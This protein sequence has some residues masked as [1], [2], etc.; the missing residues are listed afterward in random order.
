[1]KKLLIAAL[2]LFLLGSID[3]FCQKKTEEPVEILLFISTRC[4]PC[5]RVKKE[6]LP[7][8]KEKYGERV[9]IEELNIIDD[10][11]SYAKFLALGNKYNWHPKGVPTPTLFID[12]KFLVGANDIKKYLELHIDTVL[13]AKKQVR[14]SKTKA[15]SALIVSRF[16]V[17]TPIGVICAGLIDGINPCAFTAIIFFISF[18]ALRGY[19]RRYILAIGLSFISAVFIVYV[20]LGLGLFSFLYQLKAYWAVVKILYIA[21]AMLCFVLAGLAFYDFVKFRR[22]G[23]TQRLV[24]QLP[25]GLKERIHRV[26]RLHYRKEEDGGEGKN[27][28]LRLILSAFI[29]GVFVSVFEA[30]CT[31]QVYLPTIVFVL[32]MTTFK[33]KAFFYLLLYNLMF[34]LPLCLIL[35]FALWGVTSSQFARLTQ[36][37]IG[38]IKILMAVLFLGLGVFLLAYL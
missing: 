6:V 33:L 14:L 5:R 36:R 30:V 29:V 8:I 13:S 19:S 10:A 12:G 7:L 24:L 25:R 2:I 38:T 34:I 18:L 15:L 3:G 26:I 28:I 21:C 20:L 37:H 1:M 27:H 9:K 17:F 22:T 35:L 23:R 16:R 11:G 32:K 4:R 31:G